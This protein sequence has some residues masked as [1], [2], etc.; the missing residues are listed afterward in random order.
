MTITSTQGLEACLY[1]LD[2]TLLPCGKLTQPATLDPRRTAT[3]RQSASS[4]PSPSASSSPSSRPTI[5][6]GSNSTRSR[7]S[8]RMS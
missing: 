5:L 1:V 4:Y 7:L 2:P 6:H 3:A 8:S